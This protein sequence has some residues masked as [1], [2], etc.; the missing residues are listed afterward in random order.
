MSLLQVDD[1]I[2]TPMY[3]VDDITA[4]ILRCKV[5]LSYCILTASLQRGLDIGTAIISDALANTSNKMT[6]KAEIKKDVYNKRT[7]P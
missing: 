6:H 2:S 4:I 7:K 1:V 3:I 5:S